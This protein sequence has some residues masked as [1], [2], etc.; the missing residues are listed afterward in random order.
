MRK[1]LPVILFLLLVSAGCALRLG[2][3]T[4]T[5]R[6][7]RLAIERGKLTE[8]TDPVARTRSYI[9]ISKLLLSFASDAAHERDIEDLNALMDQLVA[10]MKAARDT[11][12][13]L[14]IGTGGVES[15]YAPG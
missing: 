10:T 8:L 12:P 11:V 9:R 7:E 13:I 3:M 15:A 2:R 14:A 4:P 5:Q 1:V 6:G